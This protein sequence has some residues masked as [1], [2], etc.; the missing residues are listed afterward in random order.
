MHFKTKRIVDKALIDSVRNSLCI[1]C[2]SQ[3][4]EVHHLKTK[5]S[6]GSDVEWN[7]IPACRS[8]HTKIHKKG[9]S[10]MADTFANFKEWLL[11]NG[12]TFNEFNQKWAH[13]ETN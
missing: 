3:E 7:L 4:T 2:K 9:I 8:C 12:W 5:G 6:F 10:F 11:K 13:Y 1:F